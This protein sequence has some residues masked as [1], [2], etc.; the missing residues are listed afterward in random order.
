MIDMVNYTYTD[1]NY[2]ETLTPLV[3]NVIPTSVGVAGR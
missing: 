3:T 1:F 2:D